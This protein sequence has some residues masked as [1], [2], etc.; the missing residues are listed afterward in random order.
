MIISAKQLSLSVYH[1]VD[2][3]YVKR[4]I[5]DAVDALYPVAFK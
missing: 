5:L 3:V 1:L 2:T 4:H